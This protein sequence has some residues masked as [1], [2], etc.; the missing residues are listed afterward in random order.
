MGWG[1]C[2]SGPRRYRQ[3]SAGCVSADGDVVLGQLWRMHGAM[4]RSNRAVKNAIL[5]WPGE[6]EGEAA[7]GCHCVGTSGLGQRCWET[8]TGLGFESTNSEQESSARSIC[9]PKAEQCLLCERGMGA[10]Q[11]AA[12][13]GQG[14]DG[15]VDLCHIPALCSPCPQGGNSFPS[16]LQLHG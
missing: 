14:W 11:C 6:G 5:S 16:R 1:R 3:I 8:Q 12:Q 10:A 2:G 15:A 4:W 7:V 9:S 13:L